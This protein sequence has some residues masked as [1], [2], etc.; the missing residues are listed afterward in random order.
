MVVSP[1]LLGRGAAE[2]RPAADWSFAAGLCLFLL[3]V[4]FT[5]VMYE[6]Y[7]FSGLSKKRTA[8]EVELSSAKNELSILNTKFA[9]AESRM[10]GIEE[11]LD[12]M[13]GGARAGE[14]LSLLVACAAEDAVVERLEVTAEGLTLLGSAKDERSI[15]EFYKVLVS[16]EL[17]ASVGKPLSMSEADFG[18]NFTLQCDMANALDTGVTDGA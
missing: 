4:T 7:L 16:S 14:V 10:N 15:S 6:Y 11:M 13:L 17:F 5:A 8:V 1:N 2:E 3:A 12:F 18:L 9:D